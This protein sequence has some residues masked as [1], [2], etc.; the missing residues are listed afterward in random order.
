[1]RYESKTVCT[2]LLLI[3]STVELCIN[4]F[5]VYSHLYHSHQESAVAL[6]LTFE[7]GFPDPFQSVNADGRIYLN[8]I[9][10]LTLSCS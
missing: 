7:N 4:V 3:V 8:L 6:E 1:M 9:I 5:R 2:D 10:Q